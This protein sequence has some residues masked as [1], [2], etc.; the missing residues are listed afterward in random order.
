MIYKDKKKWILACDC[1]NEQVILDSFDSCRD[2]IKENEWRTIF[3]GNE[4]E[5]YCVDCKIM[6]QKD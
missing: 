6:L 5:N 3:I 1:C 2:Y 4:Y